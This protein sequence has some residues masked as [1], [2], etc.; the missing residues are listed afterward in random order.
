MSKAKAGMRFT[1]PK[2][3]IEKRVLLVLKK[4][5]ERLFTEL[6]T[7]KKGKRLT[8]RLIHD[9]LYALEQILNLDFYQ[10]LYKHEW[11]WYFVY[12]DSNS[13]LRKRFETAE[14]VI[15]VLL[16]NDDC[17][18]AYPRMVRRFCDKYLKAIE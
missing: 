17:R 13:R 9:K 7:S 12:T 6:K 18:I 5:L 11:D 15:Q 10:E 4:K 2:D 1:S 8:R 14:T 16:A 3:P